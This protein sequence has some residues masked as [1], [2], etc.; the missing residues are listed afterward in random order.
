MGLT[1]NKPMHF[2][3]FDAENYTRGLYKCITLLSFSR[4]RL[5]K[6][7]SFVSCLRVD[8]DNGLKLFLL[9]FNFHL[10][11]EITILR[12]HRVMKNISL[13]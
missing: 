9:Y 2:Q 6:S 10:K 1:E 4:N 12:F 5:E 7:N 13:V 8:V 11:I 3:H